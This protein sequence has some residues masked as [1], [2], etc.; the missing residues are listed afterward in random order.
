MYTF[1]AGVPRLLNH[2]ER[3]DQS[4]SDRTD[5][6]IELEP[7]VGHTPD[8][9]WSFGGPTLQFSYWWISNSLPMP[10]G[11]TNLPCWYLRQR[12]IEG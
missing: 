6:E 11:D 12:E 1:I 4:T 3:K 8:N 2:A 5:R 9:Y 7:L 10:A